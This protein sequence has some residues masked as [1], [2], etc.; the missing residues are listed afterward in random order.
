MTEWPPFSQASRNPSYAAVTYVWWLRGVGCAGLGL[1]SNSSSRVEHFIREQPTSLDVHDN[2]RKDH[3]HIPAVQRRL[4]GWR[5]TSGRRRGRRRP[6]RRRKQDCTLPSPSR[7]INLLSNRG[8]HRRCSMCPN[9][10]PRTRRLPPTSSNC[11]N[12]TSAPPR[13]PACRWRLSASPQATT[14]AIKRNRKL[15]ATRSY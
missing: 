11:R 14:T 2:K 9:P 3:A 6:Q 13:T 1:L 12:T 15:V 7:S 8:N 10:A 4:P 5:Q